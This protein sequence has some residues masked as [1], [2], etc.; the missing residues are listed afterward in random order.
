[1]PFISQRR[2]IAGHEEGESLRVSLLSHHNER[3]SPTC[4]RE[5]K[6]TIQITQKKFLHFFSP[7]PRSYIRML[8]GKTGPFVTP[9]NLSFHPL[10]SNVF[11]HNLISIKP[12][13]PHLFHPCGRDKL[14]VCVVFFFDS[15]SPKS[16]AA[17]TVYFTPG[18][19]AT[20]TPPSPHR[21]APSHQVCPCCVAAHQSVSAP[22][23]PH[24]RQ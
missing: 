10:C 22:P 3:R 23:N 4:G 6:H 5:H 13:V 7:T 2:G 12:S 1:M 20:V 17:L 11:K 16:T 21:L 24:I 19:T 14:T 18:V 9:L 8:G 15:R